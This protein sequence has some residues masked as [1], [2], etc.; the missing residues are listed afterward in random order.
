MGVSG[1]VHAAAAFSC[2]K[3]T[4]LAESGGHCGGVD[5]DENVCPAGNQTALLEFMNRHCLL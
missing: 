5:V 4:R 3:S 1:E 2:D